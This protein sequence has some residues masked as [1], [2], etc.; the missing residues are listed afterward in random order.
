MPMDRIPVKCVKCGYAA[1]VPNAWLGKGIKCPKCGG[2][3]K[4]ESE[5]EAAAQP[6]QEPPRAISVPRGDNN[7]FPAVWR[8]TV[9]LVVTAVIVALILRSIYIEPIV[10]VTP[11]LS[12]VETPAPIVA[13][14]APAAETTFQPWTDRIPD[15]QVADDSSDYSTPSEP[16]T[17]YIAGETVHVG[18]TSYCV[19]RSWWSKKLSDNQFYGYT[20]DAMFLVVDLTVRNDDKKERTIPG[21]YLFDENG[22]KYGISS[23]AAC[24]EDSFG[25]FDDLNPGVSKR[26]LVVF[27]VPTN[28]DYR[29]KVSGGFWSSEYAFI[30]IYPR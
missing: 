5:Q 6:P 8:I 20:A 10:G 19:W 23:Q 2:G 22:A 14:P 25:V 7:R 11:E 16:P 4:V 26:G 13:N 17:T 27:D 28:H 3:F 18:Y 1:T 24:L 9:A 29:L 12:A 21:S 15:S 30:A